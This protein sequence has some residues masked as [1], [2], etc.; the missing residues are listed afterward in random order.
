M[1]GVITYCSAENFR[2]VAHLIRNYHENTLGLS[3]FDFPMKCLEE[4]MLERLIDLSVEHRRNIL[5]TVP[6][7]KA[8]EIEIRTEYWTKV[9]QRSCHADTNAILEMPE[10][11]E[12]FDALNK[13]GQCP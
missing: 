11:L 5:T 8:D 6:L 7:S 1:L 9:K 4:A 3:Q 13:D 12:F 2:H 10:W